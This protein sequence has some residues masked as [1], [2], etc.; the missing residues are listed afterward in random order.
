MLVFSAPLPSQIVPI[1]CPTLNQFDDVPYSIFL[2]QVCDAASYKLLRGQMS[3]LRAERLA[4][5]DRWRRSFVKAFTRRLWLI[6]FATA[7][8]E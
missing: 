1:K 4:C 2:P 3:I 8:R 7:L 5:E 6:D